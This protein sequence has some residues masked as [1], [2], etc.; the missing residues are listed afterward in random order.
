MV[1]LVAA[2]VL[3]SAC[4]GGSSAPQAPAAGE[5]AATTT[6]PEFAATSTRP[7]DGVQA[8][9]G[10]ASALGGVQPCSQ[11]NPISIAYLGPD[12]GKFGAIGLEELVIEDP[13]LVV[14]AYASAVN[15]AGGVH[16]RCVN[17]AVH[18]WDPTNFAASYERICAELPRAE[19]LVVINF[20]GD[21]TGIDCLTVADDLPMLG[22]HASAPTE[23]VVS[24]SGRLLLDDGALIY[25]VSNSVE[26]AIETG[27]IPS[28]A[29][30]GI[31][32]HMVPDGREYDAS[33][34]ASQALVTLLDT[35]GIARGL[36][37]P[38]PTA[39]GGLGAL[40]PEAQAG[41]LRSDLSAAEQ[42]AAN[43]ARAA[44]SPE[45]AAVLD[46]IEE[47]YLKSAALYR[48]AGVDVMISTA[49]WYEMRRLMRAA[50]L[51]DWHPRWIA[52]DIQEAELVLTGVPAS[53]A[54]RF[55][56][57]SSRRAA[58]DE[59]PE[60]DRGCVAL[61]NTGT[62]A[63]PFA[64]R[65]H[66]D[67]WNV[68]TSACDILDITF[69]ALT[70]A[71]NPPTPEQFVAALRQTDYQAPYGGHIKFGRNDS[72]GA[73]LFRVLQADPNCLLDD[74]GCMRALTDWQRPLVAAQ[75]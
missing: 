60:L 14:S 62:A 43:D 55:T 63:A 30:I 35:H 8:A 21:L 69:S 50:E 67:A 61:R 57:V 52:S 40:L 15:T 19:P 51:T 36:L 45:T 7:L 25:L 74:W 18:L 11:A 59:V 9:G 4:G 71:G 64:H 58:G 6:M 1:V 34:E 2:G 48:D 37:P 53:Q 24:A 70:R 56:L 26:L 72:S 32:R 68:I 13:A 38:S 29:Q 49:P 33:M 17:T 28:S 46:S 22:L 5:D 20:F 23:M 65:H 44:M 39:F 41:L 54:E 27:H 10:N 3:L 66:T 73:G 75:H 12:L 47:F 31:L 42:E 16:G